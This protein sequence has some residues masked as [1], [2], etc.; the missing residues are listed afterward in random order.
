MKQHDI[1]H[2]GAYDKGDPML[3]L[4]LREHDQRSSLTL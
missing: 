4:T 3:M 2:V 1:G